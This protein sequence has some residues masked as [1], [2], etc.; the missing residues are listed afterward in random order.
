MSGLTPSCPFPTLVALVSSPLA[1]LHSAFQLEGAAPKAAGATYR[2]DG[3]G[4]LSPTPF[5]DPHICKSGAEIYLRLSEKDESGHG[6]GP[7]GWDPSW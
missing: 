1:R 3:G 2:L 4:H 6:P 7:R 5:L